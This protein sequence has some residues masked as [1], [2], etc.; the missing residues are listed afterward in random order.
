[1]GESRGMDSGTVQ[2]HIKLEITPHAG[3]SR[4]TGWSAGIKTNNSQSI[5]CSKDTAS[6]M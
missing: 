6:V 1:M 3:L 5:K 2:A 4:T